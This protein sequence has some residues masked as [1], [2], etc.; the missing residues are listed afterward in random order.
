MKE[1]KDDSIKT[2]SPSALTIATNGI[3]H[4]PRQFMDDT[5]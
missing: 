4:S 3:E 5:V 2:I 1:S